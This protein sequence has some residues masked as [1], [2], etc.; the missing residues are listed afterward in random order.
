MSVT[1]VAT[2]ALTVVQVISAGKELVDLLTEGKISQEDFLRRWGT[3]QTRLPELTAEWQA[4][5]E[6]KKGQTA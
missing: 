6:A 1:A 2:A 3:M 5:Q 4:R